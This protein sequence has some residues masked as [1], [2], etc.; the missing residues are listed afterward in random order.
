MV[1]AE[2]SSLLILLGSGMVAAIIALTI[3]FYEFSQQKQ[4]VIDSFSGFP[5]H[6]DAFKIPLLLAILV[7]LAHTLF[8]DFKV[9]ILVALLSC[10]VTI[11]ILLKRGGVRQTSK[12]FSHHI[13]QALPGMRGELMLYLSAGLLGAGLSSLIEG[14]AITLPINTLTGS[15]A[16]IVLGCMLLA[17]R[18]G[19]HPVISIAVVGGWFLS[20]NPNHTLLATMFL[21]SWGIGVC[22]NPFSG[23]NLMMLGRYQVKGRDIVKWNS[24]YALKLYGVAAIILMLQGYWFGL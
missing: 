22:I 17:A 12:T 18:L 10:E 7:L 19:V 8:P 5:L 23:I 21:F 11:L 4:A 2:A 13:T 16:V 3:S 1:F 6:L 15:S 20:L 14:L 9:I 24:G